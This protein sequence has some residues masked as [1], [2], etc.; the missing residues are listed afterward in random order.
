MDTGHTPRRQ[1]IR[2][3]DARYVIPADVEPIRILL[4][5]DRP[6]NDGGTGTHRVYTCLCWECREAVSG[7][8]ER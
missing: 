2:E 7:E 4:V 8:V 5:E 6:Y 3:L 1:V